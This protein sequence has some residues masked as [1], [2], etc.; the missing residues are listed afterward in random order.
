MRIP[1]ANA[2]FMKCSALLALV[3]AALAL[4]CSAG[5]AVNV[6]FLADGQPVPVARGGTTIQ[7]AVEHLLAGP[8]AA[9]RSRGMRTAVP[10]ATRLRSV[11]VERRI[12]TVDLG[13]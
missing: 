3:T 1:T 10:R 2:T 11:A 7:A 12:V 5:A 8:T 13:E 6:W 4:P 9:E